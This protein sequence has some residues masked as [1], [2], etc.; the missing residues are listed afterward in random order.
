MR[1]DSPSRVTSCTD[2]PAARSI[3]ANVLKYVRAWLA[4]RP[5]YHAHFTPTYASWLNQVERWFGLVTQRAIRRASVRTTR[6]LVRRIEAFVAA[7]NASARAFA[8][9]ATP[10]SIL[11]KLERLLKAISGSRH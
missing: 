4:A 5:R 9:T 3:T 7:Y 10:E 2:R 6:E 1:D 8:W 11:A